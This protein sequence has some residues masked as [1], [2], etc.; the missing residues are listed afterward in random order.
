MMDDLDV[1]EPE[2]DGRYPAEIVQRLRQEAAE[3]RTRAREA[4][5]AR[6]AA[7]AR[8]DHVLTLLWEARRDIATRGV[9][10][11]ATDLTGTVEMLDDDGLP[12]AARIKGAAEA[13]AQSKP[14][15]RERRPSGTIDQGARGDSSEQVN[16]AERLRRAAG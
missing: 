4:D 11:D 15:L 9:L 13:L 8:T 10:A 1:D 3:R 7:E 5:E 2:E 16:L 12:D 6:T 14:H